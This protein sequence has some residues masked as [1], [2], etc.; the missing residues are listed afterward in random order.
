MTHGLPP[1]AIDARRLQEAPLGGVGRWLANVLPYLGAQADVVLLTDAG[2]PRAGGG[3]GL[4][5]A[6]LPEAPLWL[7]RACPEV[8]WI[9]FSV[10]RWLRGFRG[11]F[12]GTFNQLPVAWS[13]P[14]V[15]T[16]HD[17]ATR[18][19]PE[20]FAGNEVKRWV[21]NAQIGRAAKQAAAIHTPSEFVR[22]RVIATYGL[23][24]DQVVVIPHAVDPVF[25]PARCPEGR[26]RAAAL[27]VSGSYVVALGGARR[28]GLSV[29]V[30]AW[31]KAREEGAEEA[32]V[33]VG[34]EVPS[35]R[36]GV[37]YAGR[38]ADHEWA[39]LLAGANA[40]VYP[41]R[42]E[43]FGMPALEAAASGVPVV[44]ARVAALPEVLGD[45]AQW[46]PA[47]T[48]EAVAAGLLALLAQ[49]TRHEA[50][51]QAGLA[52]ATGGIT[53]PVAAAR[54]LDLYRLVAS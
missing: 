44:A 54:L 46:C 9:Q 19:H 43:G 35:S 36:A 10:A 16:I 20:D 8:V 27:G 26:A 41:T 11:V 38:V 48:V 5:G 42:Y 50:L 29:A 28:R 24:P 4:G 31:A 22:Q 25:T 51:R 17:L 49:P 23:H 52:R 33:V 12:H 14:M 34:S 13:G 37:F 47:P 21:W 6:T 3:S 18:D 39:Q 40:F 1:V 7:P 45:A 2:R 30:D 53:W 15:V 32:L